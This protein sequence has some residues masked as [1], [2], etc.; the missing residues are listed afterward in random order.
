MIINGELEYHYETGASGMAIY[1]TEKYPD[2]QRNYDGLHF[3]QN[4]DRLIVFDQSGSII[5]D[6]TINFVY[7]EYG[8]PYQSGMIQRDWSMLFI[9][10]YKAKLIRN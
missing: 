7:N 2:W 9:N 5:F 6:E 4:N 3:I 1:D 10:K 8:F